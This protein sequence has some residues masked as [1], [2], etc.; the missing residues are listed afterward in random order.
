MSES[1]QEEETIE[2]PQEEEEFSF[3]AVDLM[4]E[5]DLKSQIN[6]SMVK[7][8]AQALDEKSQILIKAEESFE[9]QEEETFAE[10]ALPEIE[11]MALAIT[12]GC[13]DF[14]KIRFWEA[15]ETAEVAWEE[16]KDAD[17]NVV[18]KMPYGNP[19]ETPAEGNRILANLKQ[20]STWLA[21]VHSLHEKNGMGWVSPYGCPEDGQQAYDNRSNSINQ[22]SHIIESI[23][24]NFDL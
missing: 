4:L 17:G 15:C 21:E 23:G 22:L 14:T 24:A 8:I 7:G 6:Y 3:D 11:A 1:T 10:V 12:E 9:P 16:S 19:L 2:K 18:S 5:G 13:V 20:I